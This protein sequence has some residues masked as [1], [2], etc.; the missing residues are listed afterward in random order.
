MNELII[1]SVGRLEN[2]NLPRS[3][4]DL[5]F[6]NFNRILEDLSKSKITGEYLYPNDRFQKNLAICNLR[7]IPVGARKVNL[8]ALPVKNFIFKRGFRQFLEVIF[9]AGIELRGIKP[10]Y[11]GHLDTND[12]DL[13]AE[14]NLEGLKKSY[15]RIADMLKIH[16]DVKGYFGTSWLLDPQLDRIN[17]RHRDNRE[18]V[19]KNGGK[20]YYKGPSKSALKN[21]L[22]KSSTRRKLYEEGKY[23]PADYVIVWPRQ[24]L[25]RWAEKARHI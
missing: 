25:I 16:K 9:H 12:P 10:L 17:L 18:L 6:Q 4:R 7:L 20:L 14:L 8:S 2:E 3:V 24:K 22:S 19:T 21:S 11:I 5:Y 1:Q 15:I 23:I 13:L